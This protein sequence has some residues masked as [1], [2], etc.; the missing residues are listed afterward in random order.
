MS[1]WSLVA[2][3]FQL[4]FMRTALLAGCATGAAC[5]VIGVYV[6]LNRMVFLGAALAQLSA[7]GI[8]FGFLLGIHATAPA[9][10]F[11]VGGVVLLAFRRGASLITTDA[12]LGVVFAVAWAASILMVSRSAQ[13]AEELNHM[14]QGNILTATHGDVRLLS[15]LL[16]VIILLHLLFARRFV[17]VSFDAETARTIG[18]RT[19]L[20]RF[21][22]YA[23]LGVTIA[24]TIHVVG[25][26][27]VFALLVLPPI[28]G[29]LLGRR[30]QSVFAV[31][32][33][34]ALA[35]VFAGLLLSFHADLSSGAAI[36][37]CLGVLVLLA[38][39]VSRRHT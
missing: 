5:A 21:L 17:F 13:G 28:G 2:D 37:A 6:V 16:A 12:L 4:P 18:L 29:L 10:I 23:S 19:G 24:L 20:W 14:L 34:L 39:L 3:T 33:L 25:I 7:A 22:L 11:A 9:I 1:G 8:A 30:L 26:L 15:A 38:R 36:V 31:S 27:V 35:G 32:V